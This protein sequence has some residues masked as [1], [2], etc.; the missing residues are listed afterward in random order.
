[1]A[2]FTVREG[3]SSAFSYSFEGYSPAISVKFVAGTA[4]SEDGYGGTRIGSSS[5]SINGYIRGSYTYSFGANLDSVDEEDEQFF[6]EVY[7]NG[8]LDETVT[9][10]V[11]DDLAWHGTDAGETWAGSADDDAYFAYAGADVVRGR[12]GN[13]EIDG[14]N[15]H[16]R[17]IGGNGNDV[18]IGQLGNDTLEGGNG[19]DVLTGGKGRDILIGGNGSDTLNGD[20]GHDQ[21]FG[22]GKNDTLAGGNGNDSL[23]GGMGTITF[24]ATMEQMKSTAAKAV[25]G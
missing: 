22:G 12:N 25:T 15:G 24:K 4:T 14:G 11:L 6:L 10:T 2:S 20:A 17:L 8:V 16:D 21:L 7:F 1:M 9:I 18:L 13:D 23:L 3:K 19:S 5:V